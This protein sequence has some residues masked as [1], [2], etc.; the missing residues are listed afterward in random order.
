MVVHTQSFSLIEFKQNTINH[1]QFDYNNNN[2]IKI[3]DLKEYG[4]NKYKSIL[5]KIL[6][7][8]HSLKENYRIFTNINYTNAYWDIFKKGLKKSYLNLQTKD[9]KYSQDLSTIPNFYLFFEKIKTI[10][11]DKNCKNNF[12]ETY[13]YL[14]DYNQNIFDFEQ[15][16][17]KI[18]AQIPDIISKYFR[19]KNLPVNEN[20]SLYFKEYF[21]EYIDDD[22]PLR[23]E[24]FFGEINREELIEELSGSFSTNYHLNSIR[25][26]IYY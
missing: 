13:H 15:G 23:E 17:C 9:I 5:S 10:N 19:Y 14:V 3:Y 16:L 26:R 18:L 4:F 20:N 12:D 25:D 21:K 24:T 6:N 2:E 22:I 8:Q 7:H 1:L 11:I